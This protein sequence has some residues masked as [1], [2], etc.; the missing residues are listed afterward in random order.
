MMTKPTTLT[1]LTA[2]T[3]TLALTGCAATPAADGLSPDEWLSTLRTDDAMELNRAAETMARAGVGMLPVL[4]RGLRDPDWSVRWGS[5]LAVKNIVRKHDTTGRWAAPMVAQL[6][7][8]LE[9]DES[10]EARIM[11]AQ[12]LEAM[13]SAARPALAALKRLRNNEYD[14]RIL[15]PVDR[16]LRLIE[17]AEGS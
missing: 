10:R 9:H 13:G 16:T 15:R 12:T 5:C 2:I 7:S 14:Q 4:Q 6:A 11:A 17:K 1:T 3:L 8:I